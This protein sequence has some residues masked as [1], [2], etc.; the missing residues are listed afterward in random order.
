MPDKTQSDD[1]RQPAVPTM[2]RTG[3][4]RWLYP[5]RRKGANASKR[6]MTAAVLIVLY[7]VAPW[8]QWNG[9]PLLRFDVIE[10]KAFLFGQIL[11]LSDTALIAPVLAAF[12]LL[13]FFATSIK[14]RIWCSY[15]CPQTVFVEWL[16]RP[17]EELTEGSAHHRR[18]MDAGPL[19]G[20]RIFRKAIKH[21]L[22][23]AVASIVANTFL[24]FFFGPARIANWMVSPPQEHPGAFLVMSTV[25]LGFYAD[26]AWFREQFCA[27]LC[28]YARFQS[29]I[30]DQDTPT[31]VYDSVRGDPRGQTK[32]NAANLEK[33]FGDCI[34][35]QLCVRVCP[36]GIDIRNGLQL[37]C[38]MC[39]RCIDACDMVMSNLGRPK[40]LIKIASQNE[41]SGQ[42]R[43]RFWMR[44]KTLAYA[45][46]LLLMTGA[47]LVRILSRNSL[48]ITILR[49]PGTLYTQMPDGRF[50]NLFIIHATNN[51][52]QPIRLNL[53]IK[54]PDGAK[55]LCAQ[56][57]VEIQ[58]TNDLRA[59]VIVLFDHNLTN[60]AITIINSS[61]GD[62]ATSLLIGPN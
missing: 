44:P 36:T 31:V 35:C 11:H 45:A 54:R 21:L 26:L 8:L 10:K 3:K 33:N 41:I 1:I 38:I 43:L 25:M 59:S 39:A 61:T 62:E 23:L 49:A 46:A 16:I 18:R 48:D 19:T 29:V 51:S 15:G 52:A 4:R 57:Q 34:D 37:E 20:S 60:K 56:C 40:E 7:L 47:G 55:L 2:D 6:K 5:D 12:A 24:S 32:K 58:A 27:F 22:F 9:T 42:K 30:I 13:L 17:I 14:G 53:T 50:G 28:P